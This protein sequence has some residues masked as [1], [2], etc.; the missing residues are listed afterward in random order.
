MSYRYLVKFTIADESVSKFFNEKEHAEKFAKMV[1]GKIISFTETN[2]HS[3]G[4]NR[5]DK[6]DIL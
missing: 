4:K 6:N 5:K 1:N 3:R 2:F